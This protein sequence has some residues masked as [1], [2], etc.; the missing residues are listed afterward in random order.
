MVIRRAEIDDV[1]VP[2]KFGKERVNAVTRK[3]VC[4]GADGD[5]AHRVDAA[6][7]QTAVYAVF[8]NQLEAPMTEPSTVS[9]TSC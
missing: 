3:F 8:G 2:C 7:L 6:V 4:D 1:A 5:A 9:V